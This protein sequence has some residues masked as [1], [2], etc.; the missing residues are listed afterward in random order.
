MLYKALYSLYSLYSYK[1]VRYVEF[2][3]LKDA[4]LSNKIC[5]WMI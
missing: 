4:G 5:L 3:I 1:L 2:F